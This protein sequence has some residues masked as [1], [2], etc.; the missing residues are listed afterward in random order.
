MPQ[1]A[2]APRDRARYQNCASCVYY[3]HPQVLLFHTHGGT[4]TPSAGHRNASLQT[5]NAREGK[6]RVPLSRIA[7]QGKFAC[8]R[9]AISTS[10][11]PLVEKPSSVLMIEV[12][13]RKTFTA[14][15]NSAWHSAL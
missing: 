2:D 4:A 8:V 14:I 5:G 13:E 6:I 12:S 15:T 9:L 1:F 11:M 10:M 7:R 3:E